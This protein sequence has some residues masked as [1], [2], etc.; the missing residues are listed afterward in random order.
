MV[1][2]YKGNEK[3]FN[4]WIRL[5]HIMRNCEKN[6]EQDEEQ[7]YVVAQKGL[8]DNEIVFVAKFVPE[9]EMT[10]CY[11]ME[12][13]ASIINPHG[14][15]VYS[16]LVLMEFIKE[17]C[18]DLEWSIAEK[19][20][21]SGNKLELIAF[22]D[23]DDGIN[24]IAINDNGFVIADIDKAY[25]AEPDED[26]ETQYFVTLAVEGRYIVSVMAKNPL[27]AKEKAIHEE[28]PYAN[29]GSLSDIECKLEH[30]EDT[31]RYYYEDHLQEWR[32]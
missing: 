13:S 18:D 19:L 6:N 11:A 4:N 25:E 32:K 10:L 3:V 12:D 29:F 26:K 30:V 2:P 14:D 5:F 31:D 8:T 23:A 24:D 28:Y 17:E 16:P 15:K 7:N 20:V 21:K 27:E 22:S 1:F 9:V